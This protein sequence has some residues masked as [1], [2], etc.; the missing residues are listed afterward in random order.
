M[1]EPEG[2][3]WCGTDPQY[4]AFHDEEWG[5]PVRDGSAQWTP[6]SGLPAGSFDLSSQTQQRAFI[7]ESSEALRMGFDGKLTLH[8]DQIVLS[9]SGF[10]PSAADVE[11]ATAILELFNDPSSGKG[12]LRI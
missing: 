2:C 4:V 11:D 8:P 7:E 10:S 5:V 12:A 1:K 6:W 3:P 9:N